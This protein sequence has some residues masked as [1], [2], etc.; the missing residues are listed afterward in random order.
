MLPWVCRQRAMTLLV[1]DCRKE[2]MPAAYRE[3]IDSGPARTL[4]FGSFIVARD[5]CQKVAKNETSTI[6]KTW[7]LKIERVYVIVYFVWG[8]LS[9][10]KGRP[11]MAVTPDI[12]NITRNEI[13]KPAGRTMKKKKTSALTH[14]GVPVA[15]WHLTGAEP[16]QYHARRQYNVKGP[17]VSFAFCKSSMHIKGRKMIQSYVLHSEKSSM[18]V[19]ACLQFLEQTS[20]RPCHVIDR[21]RIQICL[22]EFK[23][24]TQGKWLPSQKKRT[25]PRSTHDPCNYDTSMMHLMGRLVYRISILLHLILITE[26]GSHH[27]SH[28]CISW[29]VFTLRSKPVH[30]LAIIYSEHKKWG[31][32]RKT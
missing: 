5:R 18:H 10:T 11:V 25:F 16:G 4:T 8:V 2:A 24:F 29:P 14:W 19:M 23:E 15:G 28:W 20:Q 27:R 1:D 26:I 32:N 17:T 22:W 7:I 21:K 31:T 6:A 12:A 30:V 13:K 3:L 9:H